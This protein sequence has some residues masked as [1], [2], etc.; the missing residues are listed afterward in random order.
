MSRLGTET[1][2]HVLAKA[3]ALEAEGRDIIHLQIGEPDFDTPSNIVEA[4][5]RALREGYTH[6]TP[7]GGLPP[8]RQAI[9]DYV[10]HTRGVRVEPEQVVVTPGAKPIM[11]FAILALVEPGAEVIMPNPSFPIYESMVEFVGARPVYVRLREERGFSLDVDELADLVSDRTRLVILNSPGNPTGGV[12]SRQDIRDIA[13]VL[14][15]RDDIVILSDEIYSRI[16]Y[17]QQAHSIASEPDMQARTIILDGFSKAYAMTGWRLGYGVMRA[18]LAEA[19]IQLQINATS[20]TAAFTQ[21]AG[22]EALTGPQNSVDAMVAAFRE[23]RDVIVKGLNAIP[24][25]TCVEPQGAFYAFPNIAATGQSSDD[26]ANR[27]LYQAGVATLSGTAFGQYGEGYLRISYANSI[28]N[29]E[30]ALARIQA[31]LEPV[32]A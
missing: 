1:A 11:F 30:R 19:L 25:I 7:A 17:D 12:L 13:D 23:R 31:A 9:A 5:T 18:D 10:S 21:M 2:F 4:A 24:G 16:L 27:L 6:Y 8:V 26:L 32:G 29:I 28:P 15:P 22:V 20:C 14:R 3:K